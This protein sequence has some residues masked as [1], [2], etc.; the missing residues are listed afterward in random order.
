MKAEEIAKELLSR[1]VRIA[2]FTDSHR[3]GLK[4]KDLVAINQPLRLAN[5]PMI[6]ADQSGLFSRIINDFGT[7]NVTDLTGEEILDIMIQQITIEDEVMTVKTIQNH[8][9]QDGDQ[10]QISQAVGL[11]VALPQKIEVIDVKQFRVKSPVG[12]SGVYQHNGIAR[13]VKKSKEIEFAPLKDVLSD[14]SDKHIDADL[15]IMDFEKL[16]NQHL[17]SV[18][19]KIIGSHTEVKHFVEE[20][21]KLT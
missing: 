10:V 6:L 7:H 8:D 14:F 1:K 15:R 19:F 17:G 16:E 11:E 3:C 12:V 9:Y 5:I 2:V 13:L 20:G 18:A 4:N 21:I